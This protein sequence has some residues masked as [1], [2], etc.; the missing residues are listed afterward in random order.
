MSCFDRHLLE[1][2]PAPVTLEGLMLQGATFSGGVLTEAT[3]TTS[4]LVP[5]PPA[6]IAWMPMDSSPPYTADGAYSSPVYFSIERE[7]LLMQI[8]VPVRKAAN[9]WVLAGAAVFL[10]AE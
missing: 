4:E 7:T 10:G 2:C 3:S 5:L 9:T 6:V 8:S 1:R